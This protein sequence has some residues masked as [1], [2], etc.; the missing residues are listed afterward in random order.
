MARK[1]IRKFDSNFFEFCF[2]LYVSYKHPTGI[3]TL[4]S[5]LRVSY[6]S[7]TSLL[8][9]SYESLKPLLRVSYKSYTYKVHWSWSHGSWVK[10]QR[11]WVMGNVIWGY[12]SWVIW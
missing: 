8:G 7:L 12:R 4:T 3:L 10:G 5:L 11:S 1:L 9:V 2:P 6:K